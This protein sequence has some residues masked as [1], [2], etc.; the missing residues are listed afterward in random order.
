ME[1][2]IVV[3]MSALSSD[4][5]QKYQKSLMFLACENV[6]RYLSLKKPGDICTKTTYRILIVLGLLG[7]SVG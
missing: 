3:N 2:V 7:G 6:D 1:N 4:T 5:A